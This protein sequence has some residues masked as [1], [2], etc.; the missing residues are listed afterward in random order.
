MNQLR[1]PPM[2]RSR[3]I[4]F[5]LDQVGDWLGKLMIYYFHIIFLLKVLEGVNFVVKIQ[6]IIIIMYI[7]WNLCKIIC[8]AVLWEVCKQILACGHHFVCLHYKLQYNIIL[9]EFINEVM[10]YRVMKYANP[11][12]IVQA[13][14]STFQGQ[15]VHCSTR[16][17]FLKIFISI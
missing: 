16:G 4:V 10:V 6:T 11:F 2:P 13:M 17:W 7:P 15:S 14:Y 5:R 1:I 8:T 3:K 12:L 9:W